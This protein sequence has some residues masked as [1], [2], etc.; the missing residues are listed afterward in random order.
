MA[1]LLR[2]DEVHVSSMEDSLS[3]STN[4]IPQPENYIGLSE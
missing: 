3:L 2:A 1:H 4:E